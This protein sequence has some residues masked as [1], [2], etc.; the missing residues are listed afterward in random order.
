M[1]LARTTPATY[2]DRRSAPRTRVSGSARLRTA[3]AHYHGE[4]WDLS[5]TGARFLVANPPNEGISAL[6]EWDGR[7]VLCRVAWSRDGMSGLQFEK[8]ISRAI[9]ENCG[10]PA[11]R[12]EAVA[13]LGK[14][15]LG[16]RRSL[17]PSA[18]SDGNDCGQEP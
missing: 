13:T 1:N 5:T 3:F 9:V 12:S 6:L 7:D 18:E 8:P 17:L 16:K 11:V 2:A 4:L 14:I 15:P 10:M